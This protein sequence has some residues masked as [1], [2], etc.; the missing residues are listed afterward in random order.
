MTNTETRRLM[1]N[2]AD[3]YL[4]MAATLDRIAAEKPPGH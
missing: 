3:D 4:H 2:M 1:L